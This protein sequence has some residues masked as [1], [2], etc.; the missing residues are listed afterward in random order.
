MHTEDRAQVR[1]VGERRRPRTAHRGLAR[2]EL[3]STTDSPPGSHGPRRR[4]DGRRWRQRIRARSSWRG[5]PLAM[6]TARR[7]TQSQRA[8]PRSPTAAPSTCPAHRI[9]PPT[10][11]RS[12]DV[13]LA[14]ALVGVPPRAHSVERTLPEP[15]EVDHHDRAVIGQRSHELLVQVRRS[16]SHLSSAAGPVVPRLSKGSSE[17]ARLATGSPTVA[18]ARPVPL[19][20]HVYGSPLGRSRALPVAARRPRELVALRPPGGHRSRHRFGQDRCRDRG[21]R[22]R[23]AS[24]PFRPHPRALA[25]AH[26]AVARPA[27]RTH[28]Q[29][30]ASVG[31]A[32]AAATGRTIA[33]SSS[34][35][36]TLQRSTSPCPVPAAGS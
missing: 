22:G 32:T 34:R 5:M 23:T 3:A 27:R 9:V 20:P 28:S 18:R 33:M 2:N 16:G 8:S 15:H 12:G 4:S 19:F 29:L 30:P 13:G 17:P 1:R 31:W 21:R 36:V 10:R 6:D 11:L 25:R 26:G 24:G 35:R 14:V 7:L